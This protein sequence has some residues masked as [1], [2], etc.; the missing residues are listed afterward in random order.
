MAVIVSSLRENKHGLNEWSTSK[1]DDH[2]RNCLVV[3]TT[4]IHAKPFQAH[5]RDHSR[6]MPRKQVESDRR[7]AH[8][9]NMGKKHKAYL[10]DFQMWEVLVTEIGTQ[11]GKIIWRFLFPDTLQEECESLTTALVLIQMLY[12]S[13][14][15]GG[16]EVLIT[17]NLEDWG[18]TK[19]Y[20]Q[21][22]AF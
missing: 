13:D 1:V 3:F 2:S 19:L 7:M 11:S 15:C 14:F 8:T 21:H 10:F 22:K 4:T 17:C 20:D 6:G 16:T 5:F 9:I 18:S 12:C